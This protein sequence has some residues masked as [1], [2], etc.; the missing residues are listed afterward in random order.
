M[1]NLYKLASHVSTI[2]FLKL[3]YNLPLHQNTQLF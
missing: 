1:H 2:V 3:Q